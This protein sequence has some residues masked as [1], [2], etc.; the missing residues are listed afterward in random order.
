MQ[1]LE[2]AKKYESEIIALRRMFHEWPEL[3]GKEEETVARICAELDKIGV[4]YTVVPQGGVLAKITGGKNSGKA[5]LLRADMDA[6]PVTETA[7]NLIMGARSCVSKNEGVMHACGHDGHVAMLLGA[8]KILKEH[9]AELEGTVYLCFERGEEGGGNVRFLF[10]HI[11]K[12][13]IQIDSVFGLHLLADLPSG[14]FAVNDG[15]M[16]AGIMWFTILLEGKGGHGSRPDEA[17]SP[18][19]CFAAIYQ[20]LQAMRVSKLSPFE[21]CTYSIGSVNSG[22]RGNVIPQTLTFSGTMRAFDRDGVGMQ[23]HKELRS[24]V[25]SLAQA[26]G[27][28]ATYKNYELPGLAVVNDKKTAVW[29][30]ELLGTLVGAENVGTAQ[31]WM[32]SESY[33]QY[34]EQ[35]PGVFAFLGISNPEKGVGAAHHHPAFDLDEDVLAT[36]AAAAAA[37]AAQYLANAAKLPGGRKMTYRQLLKKLGKD[38]AAVNSIFDAV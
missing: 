19:D 24:T 28:K 21:T 17:N 5:V 4:E 18:I 8:A 26:Y 7:D 23:F 29:C 1:Y 30:R 33:A 36:G 6:L 20:R 16:M 38:E 12:Q 14:Q 32:A 3:S 25:D 37:Y 13:G 2:A 27:C 11:E 31:P 15:A 22:A 34:L 10:A 35:W 9:A